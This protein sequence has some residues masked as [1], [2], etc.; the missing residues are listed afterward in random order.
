MRLFFAFILIAFMLPSL[1]VMAQNIFAMPDS[2]EQSGF[3]IPDARIRNNASPL[4]KPVKIDIQTADRATLLDK[5]FTEC[6]DRDDGGLSPEGQ[7]MLCACT[8]SGIDETM[9]RERIRSLFED[10]AD[11]EIARIDLMLNIYTPC[12]EIPVHDL[13]IG[14]CKDNKKVEAYEGFLDKICR[15][16]ADKITNKILKDLD[17]KFMRGRYKK[18]TDINP[19]E[20]MINGYSYQQQ[21]YYA[22][23]SCVDGHRFGKY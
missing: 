7:E 10:N 22:L 19:L 18:V 15:C 3:I 4:Y 14:R 1:P 12:T 9:P 2:G 17:F 13:I 11:G 8:T 5:F 16:T 20:H 23:E 6:T 21:E